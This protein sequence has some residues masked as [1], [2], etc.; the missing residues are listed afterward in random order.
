MMKTEL[1]TVAKDAIALAQMSEKQFSQLHDDLKTLPLS[2]EASDEVFNVLRKYD[3]LDNEKIAPGNFLLFALYEIANA[4]DMPLVRLFERLM[5][6][7]EY[8]V[9][10]AD[11]D[12]K[13]LE[14]LTARLDRLKALDNVITSIKASLLL[15]ERER[16]LLSSRVITDVRPVLED[17]LSSAAV[18]IINT[19]KIEFQEEGEKKTAFIAI[20]EQDIDSLISSLERAK[21]KSDSLKNTFESSGT[22][23]IG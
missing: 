10:E 17:S 18:L 15:A 2:L 8:E 13:A 12:P 9:K 5:A 3:L 19:L 14:V 22:R 11:I 1:T 20:D 23:V 7:A 6:Y 16:L 4:G 21:R